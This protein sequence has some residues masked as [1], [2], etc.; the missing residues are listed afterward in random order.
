MTRIE[1]DPAMALDNPRGSDALYD[2]GMVD[3]RDEVEDNQ[4]DFS[5]NNDTS[6]NAWQR[7]M[8]AN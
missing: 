6:A 8:A 4:L 1:A 2:L 5:N 7:V 3:E